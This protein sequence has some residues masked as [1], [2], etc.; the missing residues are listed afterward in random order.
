MH[1]YG[2]NLD[3]ESGQ[4]MSMKRLGRHLGRGMGKGIF[5]PFQS[6]HALL[7][8][9]HRWVAV[10]RIDK[11]ILARFDK[12]IARSLGI[13]LNKALGEIERL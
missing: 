2:E 11:F 8:H 6:R 1:S 9:A 3:A 13:F 12:A 7:K 4:K 10:A 5:C